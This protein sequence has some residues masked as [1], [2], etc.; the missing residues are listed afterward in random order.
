MF[1]SSRKIVQQNDISHKASSFYHNV[2]SLREGYR[3]DIK[4][5]KPR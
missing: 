3:R 1:T 4:S 5:K 2:D